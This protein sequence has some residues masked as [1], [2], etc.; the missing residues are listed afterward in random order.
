MRQYACQSL[1]HSILILYLA[2]H[3]AALWILEVYRHGVG[4]AVSCRAR[5]RT[6]CCDSRNL[7]CCTFCAK[8]CCSC[9]CQWLG[10]VV[11]QCWRQHFRVLDTVVGCQFGL[12]GRELVSDADIG[13]PYSSTKAYHYCKRKGV[14]V[15]VHFLSTADHFCPVWLRMEPFS[16]ASVNAAGSL[17]YDN[18]V[19]SHGVFL[20]IAC[21]RTKKYDFSFSVSSCVAVSSGGKALYDCME[22]RERFSGE[23]H[24]GLAKISVDSLFSRVPADHF[25]SLSHTE[26]LIDTLA[27]DISALCTGA[28][29]VC[30]SH[31]PS[32]WWLHCWPF[33]ILRGLDRRVFSNSK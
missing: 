10:M 21:K 11:V 20:D 32:G 24:G 6:V 13:M 28:Y 17:C 31:A 1:A 27:D 12:L 26:A 19:P 2:H 30:A 16:H 14:T 8:D 4:H 5:A 23:Q 18:L 15:C 7:S 22:R 33:F 3:V 29:L 25:S 9:G